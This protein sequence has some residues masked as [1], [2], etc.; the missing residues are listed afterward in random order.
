MTLRKPAGI[1][2]ELVSLLKTITAD[3]QMTDEQIAQ[4]DAWLAVHP[5]SGLPPLELLRAT[6]AAIRDHGLI[7]KEG[8]KAFHKA[9]EKL[10]PTEDRRHSK[11]VRAA[12]ELA[13]AARHKEERATAQVE[14][15]A[16][17]E[18]LRADAGETRERN[19]ALYRANFPVS[20]TRH[21]NRRAII[22]S[23]LQPGQPL[24]LVREP[25]NPDDRWAV[26]ILVPHGGR[27]DDIGYVPR[28]IASILG[29]LMD[30]PHKYIAECTKILAGEPG[31]PIVDVALYGPNAD[32][33]AYPA[34]VAQDQPQG[35]NFTAVLLWLGIT[36]A[37]LLLGIALSR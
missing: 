4:V 23:F 12:R 13:D 2:A 27:A 7:S 16:A 22:K 3:G 21:G 32:I 17:K 30:K 15:R 36:I 33:E 26:R 5:D 25:G 34:P 9:V 18:K 11:T 31:V 8:R 24:N 35:V 37:I 20:G 6:S 19:R 29:P 1:V 10:L 14:K 28:E